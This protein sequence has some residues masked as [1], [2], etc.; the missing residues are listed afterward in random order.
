MPYENISAT[1]SAQNLSNIKTAIATIRANMPFLITLT[2]DE[3]R[4]RF[5]MGNKSLAFVSNSS[6]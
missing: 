3:R 6:V 4:K 1:L 5:K 2:A